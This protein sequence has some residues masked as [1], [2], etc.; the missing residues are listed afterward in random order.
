MDGFSNGAKKRPFIIL[1]SK[2]NTMG[3]SHML[4]NLK[5]YSYNFM[6]NGSVDIY[7]VL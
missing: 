3:E 4:Q 7:P 5:L 1:L 2:Y 6:L